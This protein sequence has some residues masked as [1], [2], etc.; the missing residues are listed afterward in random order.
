MI[1]NTVIKTGHNTVIALDLDRKTAAEINAIRDEN[2]QKLHVFVTDINKVDISTLRAFGKRAAEKKDVRVIIHCVHKGVAKELKKHVKDIE[3]GK[4]FHFTYNNAG[5]EFT[6][7]TDAD[8]ELCALYIG[9]SLLRLAWV[10]KSA[11]E[12]KNDGTLILPIRNA[13]KKVS[14][15]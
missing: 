5:N 10:D 9:V 6:I 14:A 1:F 3:K 12:F 11:N 4:W 15:L 7:K 8:H 13:D 2:V